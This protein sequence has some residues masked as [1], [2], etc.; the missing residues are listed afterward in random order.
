MK[1]N[2]Q[3]FGNKL[4]DNVKMLQKIYDENEKNYSSSSMSTEK[5]ETNNY[6]QYY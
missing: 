5:H 6:P 3:K 1:G 2:I 4:I